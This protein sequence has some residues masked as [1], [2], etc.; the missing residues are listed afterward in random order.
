MH[1][2]SFRHIRGNQSDSQCSRNINYQNLWQHQ[3]RNYGDGVELH[4]S[5]HPHPKLQW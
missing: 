4:S 2:H 3:I 5:L 1:F